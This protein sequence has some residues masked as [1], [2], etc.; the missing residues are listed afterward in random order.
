MR[1]PETELARI[2]ATFVRDYQTSKNL[3]GTWE[4]PLVGFAAAD[5]PLMSALKTVVS[6]SHLLPG[7]LLADARSVVAYF[8]PFAKGIPRGNRRERQASRE[9]AR[10]YIETNRLITAVNQHV[11]AQL[12]QQG[13]R[14]A[15]LPPTHNFDRDRLVSDWSHKHVAYIAGLG[16]FGVHHLLITA[17]GCCGRLGSL[18][19][20]CDW[21]VSKRPEGEFCLNRFNGSCLKCVAKC[22]AGALGPQSL[23]RQRCYRMLLENAA[24]Y[25]GEGLADVCGKC[26][27]VVPCSYKNPAKRAAMSQ[28]G[29]RARQN[30]MTGCRGRTA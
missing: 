27:C 21:P 24:L 14:S 28:S 4:E 12:A 3:A 8:I 6:P 23:D 5:D 15:L 16:K 29:P 7:D 18:V 1:L 9:W 17:K 11:G 13:Y 10:A 2:I 19:T 20:N 30:G 25:T 26:S 22:V